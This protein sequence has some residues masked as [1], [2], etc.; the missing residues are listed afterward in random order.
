L[1]KERRRTVFRNS[2]LM[3]QTT[4][5]EIGLA[6]WTQSISTSALQTMLTKCRPAISF[7]LGLPSPELLP[8]EQLS[9]A[10][11][12]VLASEPEALQYGP[13][14]EELRHQIVEIMR[15][16][17]VECKASEVFLTSGAQQGLSVLAKLLIGPRGHV[18][19]EKYVYTGF[20][21]AIEP[22]MPEVHTI[23]TDP[24]S[25]PD[26]DG[27]QALLAGVTNPGFLYVNST[28]H[29]PLGLTLRCEARNRLAKLAST[30]TIVEDD[31]YGLL[32]YEGDS[33]ALK[34][35]RPSRIIYVGSFSKILSPA[36]RIG[37]L[38]A[39]ENLHTALASIKE[40]SDI[41]TGTF[42]QRVACRFIASG[43]LREHV[44]NLAYAYRCRRNL[45]LNALAQILPSGSRW[46]TPSAGFFL[47]V[48][49][50]EP[51]DTVELLERA[52]RE[53]GVA[54]LPGA[55]FCAANNAPET[56][57]RS[58]RLNFSHCAEN[59]IQDGIGR[60]GAII[61]NW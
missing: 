59:Q 12:A 46:T 21:Q 1:Q 10:A 44:S 9:L 61:K 50:P 42:S 30:L 34:A 38:V 23:D 5:A 32:Q 52:L 3:T 48:E 39:P 37:W 24:W 33:P 17:G 56:A 51:Y 45:M 26:I 41:N 13:P 47:W 11:R 54:F 57:R 14:S 29:N 43:G 25:G 35:A 40:G 18:I 28:G 8:A 19:C 60:I 20:L 36:L 16:R 55:A 15:W 53:H 27:L 6:P 22:M 2:K 58:L 31:P 4:A 7:A 49:L